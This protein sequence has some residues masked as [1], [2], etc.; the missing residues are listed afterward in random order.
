MGRS[1][2]QP[3]GAQLKINLLL[4]RLPRLASGVDPAVAFAGTTHLEEGFDQ[5]EH[6]YRESMAGRLPDPIPGEVY[7]HSATDRSILHGHPGATLT[8]FGLHAPYALFA[9]DPEVSRDRAAA[10]ALR[11]LQAHLA[12]PLEDC[13]AQDEQGRP[14]IDVASP[15][16]I[17]AAVGM[18]GG[19]I[20]HG[21]LSWPWLAD[22][23]DAADAG[24]A[25]GTKIS[26]CSRIVLAGAGTVRG[27]G[28]S[29][30]G[31]AA[32]VDTLLAGRLPMR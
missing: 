6:A 29:G 20:F 25:F 30:L 19:N 2:E 21:D 23:A 27:G 7:C 9:G 10:A 24:D 28:V 32:A 31:G 12:E 11:A 16:D 15:V 18:P 13:L 17:E 5:L 26:G 1:G 4:D 22:D 14:C 3:V 8:L